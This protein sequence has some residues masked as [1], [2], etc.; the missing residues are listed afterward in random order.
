MN[1]EYRFVFHIDFHIGL[2][3]NRRYSPPMYGALLNKP[4]STTQ[5]N[6]GHD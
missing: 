6:A 3:N 4:K 1:G 2:R 5:K